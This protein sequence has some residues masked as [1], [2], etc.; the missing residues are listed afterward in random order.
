LKELSPLECG[1]PAQK[2][3]SNPPY[4]FFPEDTTEAVATDQLVPT[5]N[6]I[7]TILRTADDLSMEE[8]K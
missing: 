8:L 7:A 5:A 2:G 6:I 4:M 3:M 1:I